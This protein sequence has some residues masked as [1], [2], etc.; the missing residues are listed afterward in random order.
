MAPHVAA[1]VQVP[2]PPNPQALEDET[3]SPPPP[4]LP[5]SDEVTVWLHRGDDG[6]LA[7][8]RSWPRRRALRSP[9]LRD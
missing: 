5:K 3:R 4:P 9:Q 2:L 8:T 6:V 1:M 7:G